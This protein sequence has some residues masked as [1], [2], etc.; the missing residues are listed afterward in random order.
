MDAILYGGHPQEKPAE[1]DRLIVRCLADIRIVTELG[2]ILV[3][4]LAPVEHVRPGTAGFREILKAPQKR[5]EMIGEE[6]LVGADHAYIVFLD[7]TAHD[8]ED[9]FSQWPAA[10]HRTIRAPFRKMNGRD[11]ERYL[12][13]AEP[14]LYSCSEQLRILGIHGHDATNCD[15]L[16]R[17]TTGD[18]LF[19]DLGVELRHQENDADLLFGPVRHIGARQL[20]LPGGQ[21]SIDAFQTGVQPEVLTEYALRTFSQLQRFGRF[22]LDPGQM[23]S[24]LVVCFLRG[25]SGVDIKQGIA[26]ACAQTDFHCR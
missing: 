5:A 18:V 8:F 12:R 7:V 20:C 17:L 13:G 14:A 4:T 22:R 19:Q 10:S 6:A 23:R 15:V 25:Q 26:N 2:M 1:P 24:N 16:L 21:P 3:V 11:F 9:G